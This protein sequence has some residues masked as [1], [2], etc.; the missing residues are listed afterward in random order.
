MCPFAACGATS[1]SAIRV[2]KAVTRRMIAH[3]EHEIHVRQGRFG[4]HT[5]QALHDRGMAVM[6]AASSLCQ[7]ETVVDN[8]YAHV[9]V[10]LVCDTHPCRVVRLLHELGRDTRMERSE[11]V[12]HEFVQISG[13]G[14]R[15]RFPT[16]FCLG[17]T[18]RCGS[19]PLLL[20]L[21]TSLLRLLSVQS[22]R[23]VHLRHG[24]VRR[25]RLPFP[26]NSC[27][28]AARCALDGF[29]KPLSSDRDNG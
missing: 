13:H 14:G 5:Q 26:G 21:V 18:C 28:G 3:A 6:E 23:A 4:Q 11:L 29:G 15:Q 16:Y 20:V 27:C 10:A 12:A 7:V 19:A 1:L 25:C 22:W 8:P 17:F 2:V 9:V 24:S